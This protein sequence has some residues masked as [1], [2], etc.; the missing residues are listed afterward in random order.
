MKNFTDPGIIELITKIKGA[1]PKIATTT[2]AG[3]T[4]PDGTTVTVDANGYL[5][6][7]TKED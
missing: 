6:L 4:K 2:T 1:L 5:T 7:Y 3:I